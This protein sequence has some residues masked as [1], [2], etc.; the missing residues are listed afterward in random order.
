VCVCVCVCVCERERERERYHV[1]LFCLCMCNGMTSSATCKTDTEL[2]LSKGMHEYV[3]PLAPESWIAIFVS[4]CIRVYVCVFVCVCPCVYMCVMLAC[5]IA[6]LVAFWTGKY[7]SQGLILANSVLHPQF[8]ARAGRIH[9]AACRLTYP[10]THT[11]T[12]T[13]TQYYIQVYS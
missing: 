3:F 11:Q 2:Y 10:D 12:R 9:K 7:S 4:P 6:P 1:C 13:H 8:M 5:W